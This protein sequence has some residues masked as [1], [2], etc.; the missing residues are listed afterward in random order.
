MQ[1]RLDADAWSLQIH[2]AVNQTSHLS[3]EGVVLR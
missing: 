1:D 3:A 2:A